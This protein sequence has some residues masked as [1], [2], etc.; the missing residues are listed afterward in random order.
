M[1]A[2]A[3]FLWWLVESGLQHVGVGNAHIPHSIV[4]RAWQTMSNGVAKSWT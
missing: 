4:R 2:D 1:G 3:T